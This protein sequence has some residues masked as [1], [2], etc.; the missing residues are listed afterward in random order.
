MK[1]LEAA[2]LLAFISFGHVLTRCLYDI[3][4]LF[5]HVSLQLR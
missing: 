1:A 3:W 2:L 5:T 4:S